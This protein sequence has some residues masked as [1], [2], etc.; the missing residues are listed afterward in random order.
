VRSAGRGEYVC[1]G[2]KLNPTVDVLVP[3]EANRNVPRTPLEASSIRFATRHMFGLVGVHG[4]FMLSSGEITITDPG[5]GADRRRAHSAAVPDA[6]AGRGRRQA[7]SRMQDGQDGPSRNAA[8]EMIPVAMTNA[9]CPG[10][11]SRTG[12]AARLAN[13]ACQSA[14]VLIAATLPVWLRSLRDADPAP[15]ATA[16]AG[17]GGAGGDAA[18]VDDVWPP[19]VPQRHRLGVHQPAERPDRPDQ[20]GGRGVHLVD[21][22]CVRDR[23]D[24]RDPLNRPR[25]QGATVV[26]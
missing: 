18:A 1:D 7:A 8:V 26:R 13:R 12:L 16:G 25:N 10:F 23:G 6:Q 15:A 2:F 14:C 17:L 11:R 9:K 22:G 19:Q 5:A 20:P 24:V 21:D 3:E 4:S